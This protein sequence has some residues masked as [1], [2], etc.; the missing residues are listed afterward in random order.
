MIS[1]LPRALARFTFAMMLFL[2]AGCS[3]AAVPEESLDPGAVVV[4]GA[5]GTPVLLANGDSTVYARIRIGTQQK[6]LRPRGPVNV[7]LAIDTSGSMEGAAIEEARRAALQMIGSLKDGDRIAVVVFHSKAEV[8]LPS[9]ELNDEVRADMQSRI[10]AMAA[11]GTTDMAA[12]LQT[13]FEQVQSHF[14]PKGVN[15][16]VLLGDG[17][18]N[19][20]SSIEY[21]VRSAADRGIAITTVGLG[22][23]YDETLMGKIADMSGG[24]YRY[25]ESADKLAGFF[26]EELDQMDRVYGRRASASIT[27]GP[28]VRI[29]S[30]VGGE[31]PGPGNA[32]HIPLGDIARGDSRDLLL[33][34][35]VTPRKAGVPIELLD[36]VITFDDALGSAGRL[37]RRVYLGARTTLDESEVAKAK[38]PEVELSA[39]LAE[40]SATTIRALEMSKQGR[41]TAARTMLTKGAEAAMSQAARTPSTELTKLATNMTSVA[42]EMPLEDRVA[43]PT[44]SPAAETGYD[45]ADDALPA[46]SE[47]PSVMKLRKE[48]HQSAVEALH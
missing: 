6:A 44:P 24:R 47:A 4:E 1:D 9:T 48:V 32:A 31:T 16:V 11:R 28:G 23:D 46:P 12:G 20:G 36:A 29:D 26:Q 40:A 41:Y 37:E 8:L 13:A 35:T 5:L 15:R 25:I 33:R 45:F 21:T 7:A 2:L 43:V 19:N 30:V 39:A 34:L 10:G 18:P 3:P 22:L 27:A 14:E 17:I 42:K 38:V